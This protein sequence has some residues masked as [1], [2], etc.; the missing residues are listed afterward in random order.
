VAQCITTSAIVEAER[1]QELARSARP[2]PTARATQTTP[3]APT[4]RGLRIG[5]G[6]MQRCWPAKGAR[7]TVTPSQGEPGSTGARGGQGVFG[8]TSREGEALGSKTQANTA[9]V[10]TSTHSSVH[11]HENHRQ[12]YQCVSAGTKECYLSPSTSLSPTPR[13]E[14]STTQCTDKAQQLTDL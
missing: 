2:I 6:F 9:A 14:C 8:L 12:Q 4:T 7:C 11:K 1:L 5:D 13:Q 3:A 10:N